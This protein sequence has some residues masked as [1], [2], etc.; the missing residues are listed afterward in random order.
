MNV[1]SLYLR[2]IEPNDLLWKVYF[3]LYQNSFP[4]EERRTE[5]ELLKTFANPLFCPHQI[6]VDQ[7]F[8]G[9]FNYWKFPDFY[10]IEHFA[11]IP[12]I[13]GNGIGKKIIDE[14]M[15]NKTVV[16]ECEPAIDELSLRRLNFY[17]NLGFLIFPFKYIQPPYSSKKPS[18]ELLLLSNSKILSQDFFEQ[19]S[20][21]IANEVYQ[22]NKF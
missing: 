21:K 3:T 13:R 7:S 6:I 17:T 8:V 18:I 5:E 1:D 19:M 10:Y 14:F 15:L 2:P 9:L 20:T 11:I 22:C 4:E 16:L 12:E